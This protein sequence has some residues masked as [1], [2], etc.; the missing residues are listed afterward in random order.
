[1][2]ATKVLRTATP[3]G[4]RLLL[5]LVPPAVVGVT[6]VVAGVVAEGL[7]LGAGGLPFMGAGGLPFMGAGGLPFTGA[8]GLPFTGE[9]GFPV[10]GGAIAGLTT[11]HDGR[12]KLVPEQDVLD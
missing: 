3:E 12:G 8:G 2:A 5:L 10:V 9:G 6:D 11:S 1:M 4:P 7:P